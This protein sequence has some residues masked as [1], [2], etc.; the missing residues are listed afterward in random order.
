MDTGFS[1]TAG[2][3]SG[4]DFLETC[5]GQSVTV[6]E[7]QGHLE[8][9]ALVSGIS[10]LDTR[11]NYKGPNQVSEEDITACTGTLSW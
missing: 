6:P 7:F 1:A 2:S 8:N 5:V 4:I 10:F 3:T 9:N 11:I